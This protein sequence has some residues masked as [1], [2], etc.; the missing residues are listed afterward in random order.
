MNLFNFEK[1]NLNMDDIFSGYIQFKIC[2]AFCQ[3]P[4]NDFD[5]NNKIWF[6][7]RSLHALGIDIVA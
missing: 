1:D 6:E 4:R 3:T 7:N 2:K 5:F